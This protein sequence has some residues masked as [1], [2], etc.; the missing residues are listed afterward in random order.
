MRKK[1]INVL[2]ASSIAMNSMA[3]HASSISTKSEIQKLEMT[4][5][6]PDI[7][8]SDGT[9]Y[10]RVTLFSAKVN[11][12]TNC[13]GE[14]SVTIANA[15]TD[16]TL[17]KIWADFQ[18]II[19][20]LISSGG[21]IY[22]ASL[23]ISKA[24]PQLYQLITNGIDL[25]FEDFLSA[26]G[27]CED[28]MKSLMDTDAA[29]ALVAAGQNSMFTKMTEAAATNWSEDIKKVTETIGE[30]PNEG[31]KWFEQLGK[32]KAG[33]DTQ[34]PANLFGDTI[35]IG[36]CVMRGLSKETCD[37]SKDQKDAASADDQYENKGMH[38]VIFGEG[39]MEDY[40]D[41]AIFLIGDT[42]FSTCIGC[43]NV[44][45]ESK[46]AKAFFDKQVGIV[47]DAIRLI[48]SKRPSDITEQ[49]F[50]NASAPGHIDFDIKYFNAF[51]RIPDEITKARYVKMVA[52]DVAFI[53]T[54]YAVSEV[55]NNLSGMATDERIR[56]IGADVDI[57]KAVNKLRQEM[58][59][60]RGE[61]MMKNYFITKFT[62]EL[63]E[64]YGG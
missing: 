58:T 8:S 50:T 28:I 6:A 2:L 60:I 39:S 38:K 57:D 29:D 35:R 3:V 53:R 13:N 24:N 14:V 21:A 48:L 59:Q 25:G 31:F 19:G 63:F 56:G 30:A 26:V 12:P 17:Q 41:V 44:S 11:P 64:N 45:I 37:P 33:G 23:Y 15:F 4:V 32:D 18:D 20:S 5:S 43:D 47:S 22:L 54:E 51:K 61:S 1:I 42:K 16:G 36:W 52:Y 7:L 40:S 62:Q 46:G 9:S 27:K 49:M 34:E 10:P 55:A